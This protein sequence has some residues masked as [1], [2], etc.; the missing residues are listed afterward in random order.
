MKTMPLFFL[1]AVI[2][3][4]ASC[5]MTKNGASV[6][7]T[8][9][10]QTNAQCGDCRERIEEE[11]NFTKGVIFAELDMETKEL[12]VKYNSNKISPDEIRQQIASIGYAADDVEPV[13]KAQAAL[14]KC[15]QPGG[16]D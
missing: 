3:I 5:G 10:I 7:Q 1:L 14:S 12:T 8:I 9:S 4:T 16:H 6:K 11:L 13:K 2:A 15:C